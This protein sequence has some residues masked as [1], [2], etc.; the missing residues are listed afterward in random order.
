VLQLAAVISSP[1][2]IYECS[3]CHTAFW[4]EKEPGK[5]RRGKYC[6]DEHR[7]DMRNKRKQ[8]KYYAAKHA[9]G[10]AGS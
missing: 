10:S 9:T 1:L 8:L 4:Q 6:S 5:R 2:G 7:T 3:Y